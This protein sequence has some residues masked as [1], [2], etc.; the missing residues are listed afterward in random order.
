MRISIYKDVILC[1]VFGIVYIYCKLRV[2]K[3]LVLFFDEWSGMDVQ[4]EK[5]LTVVVLGSDLLQYVLRINV[6]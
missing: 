2:Q 5:K 6:L 1:W 3:N 4:E